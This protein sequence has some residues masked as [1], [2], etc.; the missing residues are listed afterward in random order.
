MR[1]VGR[2]TVAALAAA[3][4][5]VALGACGN[6]DAG[7]TIEWDEVAAQGGFVQDNRLVVTS[8]G[9]SVPV[10]V[11][12]PVGIGGTGY[13]VRGRVSYEGVTGTGYLEMWSYFSDGGAYF[14]RTL[15][16]EGPLQALRGDSAERD[17]EL[18]FYLNGAP[19]PDRLE[20]NVV[21]PEGGTV[22]LGPL[23]LVSLD[24]G[25]WWDESTAGALGA[26][27]GITIGMLGAITG[28]LAGRGRARRVVFALF[29]VA[30]VLGALLVALGI[31]AVVVGQPYAVYYPLLLA[32][33]LV[34]VVFA[35]ATPG[36]RRRYQEQELR[37]MSAL[38]SR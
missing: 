36:V 34:V 1:I 15:D 21:L 23:E 3:L 25:V 27:A 2:R 6:D 18:P 32:G 10:A 19:S 35:G 5:V 22:T 24:G 17:Y 20:I 9:G 31:T 13:E 26:I 30:F 4:A 37:R 29:A 12:E 16:T 28:I 14:T 11:I 7:R 33:G 38:D 8:D